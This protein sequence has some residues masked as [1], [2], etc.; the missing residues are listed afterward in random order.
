MT[1]AP[2]EVRADVAGA[3]RAGLERPVPGT[4]PAQVRRAAGELAGTAAALR[5]LTH[6][7]RSVT[8]DPSLWLGDAARAFAEIVAEAP[9]HL[10]AV[11]V[12]YDGCAAILR[13]YA[14]DLDHTTGAI[15]QARD[16]LQEAWD[17]RSVLAPDSPSLPAADA[18]CAA[19]CA[20]LLAA[21]ARWSEAAHLRARQLRALDRHDPLRNPHGWHAFVDSASH[22][23]G[24]L[25]AVTGD[26]GLLAIVVCPAAAPLLF[27][28]SAALSATTLAL[29]V[30]RAVQFR[31]SVSAATITEDVV[32]AVPASAFGKAAVTGTR[33]LTRA[34][35]VL[36]PGVAA[37]TAMAGAVGESVR[38]TWQAATVSARE[39]G[40]VGVRGAFGQAFSGRSVRAALTA[41]EDVGTAGFTAVTGRSPA[42]SAVGGGTSGGSRAGMVASDPPT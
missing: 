33:A 28:A 36:R 41:W 11:S 8:A 23:L 18:T 37:A 27:A 25:S 7:V 19:A 42:A 26:L 21:H 10:D 29:D 17:A 39:L 12:R 30:E 34:D 5:D 9:A 20:R 3:V 35:G 2:L 14:D 32:G 1:A 40:A 31:E 22:V 38:G 24:E 13:G 16:A 6:R 15:R 4:D